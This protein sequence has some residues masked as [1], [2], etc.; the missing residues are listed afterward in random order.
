MTTIHTRQL[1]QYTRQLTTIHTRHLKIQHVEKVNNTKVRKYCIQF[2][3][4]FP[5]TYCTH[6]FTPALHF[7]PLYYSYKLFPWS[8]PY[9]ALHF[10]SLHFTS[11][12]FAALLDNFYFILLRFSTFLDDFQHTISSFNSPRLHWTTNFKQFFVSVMN[13]LLIYLFASMKLENGHKKIIWL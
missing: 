8:L 11:F 13:M 10:T 6:A 1:Q 5:H 2:L 12:H 4:F 9:T 7:S 3:A